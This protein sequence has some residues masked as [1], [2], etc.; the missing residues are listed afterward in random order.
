MPWMYDGAWYCDDCG[1]GIVKA[2]LKDNPEPMTCRRCNYKWEASELPDADHAN[3]YECPECDDYAAS[4]DNDD[5]L[6]LPVHYPD[7]MIE[8]PESCDECGA[9]VGPEPEDE[10]EEEEEY[11]CEDCNDEGC[12]ACY[13]DEQL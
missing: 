10:E 1:D 12:E 11:D 9:E 8:E 4:F 2:Q 6:S 13:P 7:D 5:S 3:W